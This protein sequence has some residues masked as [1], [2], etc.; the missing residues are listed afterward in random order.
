MEAMPEIEQDA[1]TLGSAG[2]KLI[3][4][5]VSKGGHMQSVYC[6]LI[7]SSYSKLSQGRSSA[8]SEDNAHIK[9]T[10]LDLYEFG[11]MHPDDSRRPNKPDRGFNDRTCAMLLLPYD[12][13][14]LDAR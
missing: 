9:D 4:K 3:A 8:R 7:P 12:V 1:T 5:Y 2:M 14:Y 10:I 6:Q 13:D 11:Q